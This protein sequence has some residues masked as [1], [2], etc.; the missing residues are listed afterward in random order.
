ELFHPVLGGAVAVARR[1]VA[2][3]GTLRQLAAADEA[4][5]LA[6]L[7]R[8]PA[9]FAAGAFA[10]I[11]A[12]RARREEVRRQ[13]LVERVD[14]LGDPKLLDVADGGGEFAPEIPQQITPGAL[15]VGNG[16]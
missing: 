1:G 2:R 16:A 15:V 5:E 10:W 11:G 6:E 9:G 7:E 4:A 13:H 8:E 14:H 3:I 12:V